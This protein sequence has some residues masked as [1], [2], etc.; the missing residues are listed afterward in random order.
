MYT[1]STLLATALLLPQT[2]ATYTLTDAFTPSNF[3]DSFTFF[4]GK[5]PTNGFV[6]YKS[7]SDAASA[8]LISIAS[9]SN[10]ATPAIYMGVDYTTKNPPGGRASVRVISKKKYN[11]GLFIFDI[12]HNPGGECGVWP[13]AWMLSDGK[14]GEWPLGGEI[15]VF[16]GVNDAKGNVMTLHTSPDCKIEKSS[17][18]GAQSAFRGKLETSDCDV[19]APN[20]DKNK[21]CGIQ[22]PEAGLA[23]SY[24]K[25]M[26]A[27]GGGV[28]ATLWT[29]QEISIYYFPR[30]AVP[31][32]L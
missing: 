24:G 15:D 1:S 31:K 10:N 3:F 17:S 26:N 4:T 20:Q 7:L 16:E 6:S 19:N 11:T 12:E 8:N 18:G 27:V 5:D 23:Q 13:A 21:G 22:H 2:L 32:D 29:N 30:N 25:G 14:S 9:G 28:Y